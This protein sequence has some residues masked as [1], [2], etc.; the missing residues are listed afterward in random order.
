MRIARNLR[1]Q[2]L[3]IVLALT[4]PGVAQRNKPLSMVSEGPPQIVPQI[5]VLAEQVVEEQ[6]P[7]LLGTVHPPK[8]LSHIEPGQCIRF[9]VA[10]SGDGRDRLLKQTRFAFVFS[11]IGNTKAFPSAPP[12]AVKLTTPFMSDFLFETL[13]K[14]RIPKELPKDGA[15][16][17]SAHDARWCAPPDVQDGTAT[18]EGTATLPDGKRVELKRRRIE[19]KTF[20]TAR[21]KSPWKNPDEVGEWTMHY[22]EAPDPAQLLPA[23]RVVANGKPAQDIGP[24]E[25]VCGRAAFCSTAAFFGAALKAHPGAAQELQ[26]R[27]STEDRWTRLIGTMALAWGGYPTAALR[28]SFDAED[29]ALVDSVHLPDA[30]DKTPDIEIGARQDMLW[31]MFFATGRIEPVRAVASELAWSEDYP[32]MMEFRRLQRSSEELPDYAGRGIGYVT[33]GWSMGS[34]S[35]RD[36]LLMDYVDALKASPDT[37]AAVKKELETLLTNPAFKMD[38][39]AQ[40]PK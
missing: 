37:P 39:N 31:G 12:Q 20:E 24:G 19:I 17:A 13:F 33:A 18:V 3:G 9:A 30:F 28:D 21:K 1:W 35:M 38:A 27:L 4:L 23:L 14:N 5:Q 36:A 10:A 15:L 16:A 32:K 2:G 6:W 8:E 34:I 29:K 7:L 26:K 11:F 40:Q 25:A 22:H